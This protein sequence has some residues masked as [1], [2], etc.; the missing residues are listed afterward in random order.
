MPNFNRLFYS[1][2]MFKDNRHHII[3]SSMN[4][5]PTKSLARKKLT[6]QLGTQGALGESACDLLSSCAHGS[7]LE[8]HVIRIE[9]E[10]RN[11]HPASCKIKHYDTTVGKSNLG[12]ADCLRFVK[13]SSLQS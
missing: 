9:E 5:C 10:R 6:R 7:S 11:G 4:K 3:A 13:V 12:V 2:D 1:K 8:A